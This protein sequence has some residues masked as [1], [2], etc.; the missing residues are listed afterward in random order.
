MLRLPHWVVSSASNGR[1]SPLV[2][3][4]GVKTMVESRLVAL[5]RRKS[6]SWGAT[7]VVG[8]AILV[9]VREDGGASENELEASMNLPYGR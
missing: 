5:G 9:L 4:V 7:E 6:E 8:P 2:S 3:S 1:I